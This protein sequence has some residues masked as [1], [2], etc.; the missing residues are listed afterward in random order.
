LLFVV[1]LPVKQLPRATKNRPPPE[2]AMLASGTEL[3]RQ[4]PPA[5]TELSPIVRERADNFLGKSV[6]RRRKMIS[7]AQRS[8]IFDRSD[9]YR[10]KT[11]LEALGA[12]GESAQDLPKRAE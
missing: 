9:A 3:T 5:F 10:L 12:S 7:G 8:K 11:R 4:T 1:L 2:V 6:E